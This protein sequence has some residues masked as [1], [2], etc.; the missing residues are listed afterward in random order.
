[1]KKTDVEREIKTMTENRKGKTG[2]NDQAKELKEQT[3]PKLLKE[4]V[5]VTFTKINGDKRVMTC[6]L[7]EGVVP[8]ATKQDPASLK[9][10]RAINPEVQIITNYVDNYSSEK[11]NLK[12]KTIYE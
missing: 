4:E 11:F 7:K 9:K 10:I 2:M 1:M 5:V 3:V 12:I 8:A 6:T